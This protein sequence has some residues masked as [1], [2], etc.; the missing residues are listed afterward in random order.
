MVFFSNLRPEK[1]LAE[2]R[3][4]NI[5]NLLNQRMSEKAEC[6]IKLNETRDNLRET[7][8]NVRILRIFK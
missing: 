6:Q 1:V 8:Q 2:K 7:N 4:E 3:H 5:I